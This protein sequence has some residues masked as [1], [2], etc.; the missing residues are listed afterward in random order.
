V[1]TAILILLPLLLPPHSI[2]SYL[3]GLLP[4]TCLVIGHVEEHS[5]CHARLCRRRR[6]PPGGPGGGRLVGQS[7]GQGG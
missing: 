3:L 7:R 5:R 2:I 4:F 1:H 6:P